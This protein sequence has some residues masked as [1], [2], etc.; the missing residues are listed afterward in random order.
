MGEPLCPHARHSRV[1]EPV[2]VSDFLGPSRSPPPP[3]AT[4]QP[5]KANPSGGHL[6]G[7]FQKLSSEIQ[8]DT[9]LELSASSLL[10]SLLSSFINISCDDLYKNGI[11]ARSP[12]PL[13]TPILSPR[14]PQEMSGYPQ[15]SAEPY[16]KA[17]DSRLPSQDPSRHAAL[18]CPWED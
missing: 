14:G 9:C 7:A 13:A 3:M 2:Q 8:A 6:I 5:L 17:S 4:S 18:G 1:T 12:T 11:V 10:N 16:G 15:G